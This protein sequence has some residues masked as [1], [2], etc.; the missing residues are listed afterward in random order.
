MDDFTETRPEVHT[1]SDAELS[2]VLT[3]AD[4]SIRWLNKVKDYALQRA[5]D[6]EGLPGWKLV[7]GRSR[8]QYIDEDQIAGRLLTA[9]YKTDNIYKPKEL[10][11]ITAMEKLITKKTFKNLL[12]ALVEKPPGKPTLVPADDKRPELDVT[13]DFE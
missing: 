1:L 10:L 11:G 9:G 12:E 5:L 8:R 2:E 13:S 6:G 7:E 3:K 4:E